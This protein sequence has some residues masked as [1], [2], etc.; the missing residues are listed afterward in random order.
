MLEHVR[1]GICSKGTR[2]P[3]SISAGP[4]RPTATV[5][6]AGRVRRGER[7]AKLEAKK[8]LANGANSPTLGIT[9]DS[10][11]EPRPRGRATPRRGKQKEGGTPR[12]AIKK[13]EPDSGKK[14]EHRSGCSLLNTSDQ[15]SND[16]LH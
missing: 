2:N 5:D 16:A 8:R 15:L 6:A 7:R 10:P 4:G 12:R 9:E 14:F 1:Q 11:Q 13:K 3:G